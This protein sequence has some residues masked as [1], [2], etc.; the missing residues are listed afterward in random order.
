MAIE[1]AKCVRMLTVIASSTLF[2]PEVGLPFNSRP[3][4]LE[5]LR[6]RE[7]RAQSTRFGGT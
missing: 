1:P 2:R 7:I 6:S 3:G 4:K 5:P